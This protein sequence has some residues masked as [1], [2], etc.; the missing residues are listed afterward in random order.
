MRLTGLVL[1]SL[2][3]RTKKD[4]QLSRL[5]KEKASLLKG[6]FGG[7]VD[8]TAECPHKKIEQS[9]LTALF[10]MCQDV[11]DH[12]TFIE[13]SLKILDFIEWL[14]ENHPDKASYHTSKM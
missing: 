6:R 5:V 11:L 9:V 3:I 7:I 2:F 12:R 1:S 4:E 13:D 8:T 10:L 14:N